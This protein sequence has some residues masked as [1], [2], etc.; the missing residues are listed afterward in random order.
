MLHVAPERVLAK[1][2]E[3][4]FGEYVSIDVDVRRAM[5]GMDLTALAFGDEYFD[6][7]VCNHAHR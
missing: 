6:A 4:R 1:K 2:L 5:E 3:Q 7:I